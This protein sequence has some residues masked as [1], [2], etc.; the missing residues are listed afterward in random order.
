M[1]GTPKS[2]QQSIRSQA[3][4]E[5][6]SENYK[7]RVVIKSCT[8]SSEWFLPANFVDTSRADIVAG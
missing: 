2:S 1:F 6:E 4:T 5:L 8:G 3:P 7:L